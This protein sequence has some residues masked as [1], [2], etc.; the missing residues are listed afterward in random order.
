MKKIYVLNYSNEE[1]NINFG[2]FTTREKAEKAKQ[3]LIS[4]ND[5]ESFW[6]REIVIEEVILNKLLEEL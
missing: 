5:I 3:K 1:T 4:G 6:D 2:Y